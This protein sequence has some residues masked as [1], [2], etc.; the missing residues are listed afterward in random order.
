MNERPLNQAGNPT[1]WC[2]KS[3]IV[4]GKTTHWYEC[5]EHGI[6][7]EEHDNPEFEE[8]DD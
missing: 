4:M 6:N 8:E 1:C 3:L 2:G 7:C 5:P